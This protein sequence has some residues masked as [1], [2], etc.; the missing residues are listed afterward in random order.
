MVTGFKL[1]KELPWLN[2]CFIGFAILIILLK[3]INNLNILLFSIILF[4]IGSFR[5]N[6]YVEP[7]GIVF[8]S[9]LLFIIPLTTKCPF[10]EATNISFETLED[11]FTAIK[12]LKG[13]KLKRIRIQNKDVKQVKEWIKANKNL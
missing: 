8:K 5:E 10:H 7:E 6:I 1:R 11:G 2:F 12:Y 4:V 13:N 9:N 3:G